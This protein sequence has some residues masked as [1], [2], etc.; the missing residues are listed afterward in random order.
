MKAFILLYEKMALFEIVLV[1]YFMNERG[2]VIF[3]GEE[4]GKKIKTQEGFTISSDIALE[5]MNLKEV[6]MFIIPGGNISEYPF[7]ENLKDIVKELHEKKV[8]LGGICSGMTFLTEVLCVPETTDCQTRGN[9]VIA[10][11]NK[12]ID[13]ALEIGKKAGIFFNEEDL[14]ETIEYFKQF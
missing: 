14:Q 5:K 11:G 4:S 12:Y 3:V 10:T 7:V 13:F 6:D 8:I 9:L 2:H 1:A